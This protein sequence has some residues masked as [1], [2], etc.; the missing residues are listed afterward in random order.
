MWN[1]FARALKGG[2]NAG[3]ASAGGDVASV[4]LEGTPLSNRAQVRDETVVLW[5]K[6]LY[7]RWVN[8]DRKPEAFALH[9]EPRCLQVSGA[10]LRQVPGGVRSAGGVL[11]DGGLA[12][13]RA[14]RDFLSGC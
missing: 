3:R 11:H 14:G 12:P 9:Y 2:A 6:T 13:D 1:G 4:V 7:Y 5:L 8:H 10:M